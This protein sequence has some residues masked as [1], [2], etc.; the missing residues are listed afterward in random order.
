MYPFLHGKLYLTSQRYD[1]AE[2]LTFF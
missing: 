1:T 2:T